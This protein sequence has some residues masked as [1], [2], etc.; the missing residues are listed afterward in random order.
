MDFTQLINDLTKG[1][2]SFTWLNAVMIVV[3][4]V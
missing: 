2:T 3:A 1:F 4:L